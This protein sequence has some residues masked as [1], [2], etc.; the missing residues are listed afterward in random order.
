MITRLTCI[1]T[2]TGATVAACSSIH[3][4]SLYKTLGRDKVGAVLAS[5]LGLSFFGHFLLIPRVLP[6]LILS[7]EPSR[8][9]W[10]LWGFGTAATAATSTLTFKTLTGSLAPWGKTGIA[11]QIIFSIAIGHFYTD[12]FS[13]WLDNFLILKI[14]KDNLLATINQDDLKNFAAKLR[15]TPPEKLEE[16]LTD[17]PLLRLTG[18][19]MVKTLSYHLPSLD[20]HYEIKFNKPVTITAEQKGE[21]VP[22]DQFSRDHLQHLSQYLSIYELLK[23]SMTCKKLYHSICSAEGVNLWGNKKVGSLTSFRS[24]TLLARSLETMTRSSKNPTFLLHATVLKHALFLA[25]PK[26]LIQRIGKHLST[27]Q[28]FKDGISL[29]WLNEDPHETLPKLL[30]WVKKPQETLLITRFLREHPECFTDFIRLINDM[31]IDRHIVDNSLEHLA[32]FGLPENCLDDLCREFHAELVKHQLDQQPLRIGSFCLSIL[33]RI[34]IDHPTYSFEGQLP[35]AVIPSIK[36][37]FGKPLI[38]YLG[39]EIK[40]HLS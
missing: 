25:W 7:L 3:V 36:T 30:T 24:M 5:C 21:I 13:I 1:T 23:L 4:Y 20:D 17:T 10:I 40:K 2:F 35:P 27:S 11:C 31:N 26:D 22:F 29:L 33:Q 38:Y 34:H 39:E 9:C 37:D 16:L 32:R 12:L 28:D 8:V 18:N 15:N 6:I 19:E 14:P